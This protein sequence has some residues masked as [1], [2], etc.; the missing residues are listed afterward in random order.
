MF[1]VQVREAL[2]TDIPATTPDG[3]L[4][5]TKIDGQEDH[6]EEHR[7]SIT[8]WEHSACQGMVLK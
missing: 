4:R 3:F 8:G 6:C 2:W 7:A 1:G 5:A